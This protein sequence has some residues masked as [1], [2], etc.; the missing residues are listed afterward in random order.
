MPLP[1]ELVYNSLDGDEVKK[2]LCARFLDVLNQISDFR[3]LITFPRVRMEMNIRLEVAGRT[4]PNFRVADDVVIRVNPSFIPPLD[5]TQE[6]V[7]VEV[8]ETVEINGDDMADGLPPDQLR[9]EHSLPIPT[10]QRGRGGSIEDVPTLSKRVG[11][12]DYAAF[13]TND[14]GPARARTGA[15]GIM[16]P[17]AQRVQQGGGPDVSLADTTF[18]EAFSASQEERKRS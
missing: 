13:V 2:I 8:D 10:P 14:F 5:P 6:E 17:N 3:S 7:E 4:P 15:E 12:Y 18:G 11:R 9:E 1:S 16:S